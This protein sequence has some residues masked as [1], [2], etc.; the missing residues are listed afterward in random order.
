MAD[1]GSS[2]LMIKLVRLKCFHISG[3]SIV[4]QNSD[5][6]TKTGKRPKT[7]NLGISVFVYHKIYLSVHLVSE[8]EAQ[9]MACFC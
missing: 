7:S 4:Y 5:N 8:M 6:S 3:I 1:S 2:C 9:P